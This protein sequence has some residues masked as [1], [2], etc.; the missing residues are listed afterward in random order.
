MCQGILLNSFV[1]LIIS[2]N[3]MGDVGMCPVLV[4]SFFVPSKFSLHE[5][6]EIIQAQNT[7]LKSALIVGI[8]RRDSLLA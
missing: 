1:A 8:G 4:L 6:N 2:S 5:G 3:T 7:P